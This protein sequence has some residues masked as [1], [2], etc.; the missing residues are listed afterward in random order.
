M[1]TL[2]DSNNN[3]SRLWRFTLLSFFAVYALIVVCIGLDFSI[4]EV[5]VDLIK[6][7]YFG[8]LLGFG[9]IKATQ[10][11]AGHFIAQQKEKPEKEEG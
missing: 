7:V 4:P 2:N 6:T 5:A 3:K 10:K 9:G 1:S 11:V 8:G